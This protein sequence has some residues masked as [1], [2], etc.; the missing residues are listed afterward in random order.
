[1]YPSN[2]TERPSGRL[3][4]RTRIES[5]L[6]V[7]VG[8]MLPLAAAPAFAH[9]PWITVHGS[10]GQAETFRVHFGH[11]F[12][13]DALLRVDRLDGVRVV[14]P[15]GSVE[16]LELE[17]RADH[18]LPDAAEGARMIVAEE[19]P[20]YWSRTH[21]GGRRASREQY[22]DAF[23]CSQSVNAMK[24]IAGQGS[25]AAWQHRQGH[26]LEVVPLNDPTVLR[27]GDPLAVQVLLHGE[28]WEGEVRATYAGYSSSGEDDYALTVRANVEGVARMVPAVAGYWLVQAHASEDYPDPAVCDRRSYDSTLTFTIR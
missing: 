10:A 22:P 21:E 19:K 28:P 27:G 1:M 13:E 20:A 24:A 25:G 11:S 7:L 17:E 18:P 9:Y 6:H 14:H 8:L 15:D 3:P 4:A 23:S 5:A 26:A 12:P 16:M 2:P